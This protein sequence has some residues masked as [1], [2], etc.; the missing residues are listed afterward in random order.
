MHRFDT[1][2][3]KYRKTSTAGFFADSDESSSDETPAAAQHELE[4]YFGLP[5]VRLKDVRNPLEWWKQHAEEYSNVAVMARQYLGCPAS[6]A[7]VERLFSQV[8]I[9]WGPRSVRMGRHAM[10]GGGYHV[11]VCELAV[12]LCAT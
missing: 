7:A 1:P 6:S 3:R 5:Q 12:I 11:C 9:A 8:G 10:H 2:H 4:A